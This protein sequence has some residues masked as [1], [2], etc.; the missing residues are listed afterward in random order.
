MSTTIYDAFRVKNRDTF[1]MF[2]FLSKVQ[3]VLTEPT[4]SHNLSRVVGE[5]LHLLDSALLQKRQGKL[6]NVSD[7]ENFSIVRPGVQE[8]TY[9]NFFACAARLDIQWDNLSLERNLRLMFFENPINK[10][11]YIMVKGPHPVIELFGQFEEVE[12]FSYWNNT[13]KPDDVSKRQWNQRRKAWDVTL[14][15]TA[16]VGRLSPNGFRKMEF[17]LLESMYEKITTSMLEECPIVLPSLEVRMKRIVS[18]R[19]T[20][21]YFEGLDGKQP[22]ISKVIN[23]ISDD[24]KRAEAEQELVDSGFS[25]PELTEKQ[26]VEAV[27]NR[28]VALV[29]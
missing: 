19:A 16:S 6:V 11:L 10:D 13:D 22:D 5:S 28:E 3:K 14:T 18:L 29:L 2:S 25:L 24:E 9:N 20:E 12:D 17:K 1:D 15:Y 23:I 7:M 21:R 27:M 26:F 8:L 4:L